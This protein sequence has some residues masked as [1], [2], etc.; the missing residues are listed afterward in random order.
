MRQCVCKGRT[1]HPNDLYSKSGLLKNDDLY[2][3]MP[4]MDK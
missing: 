2:M 4:V 1:G 3:V